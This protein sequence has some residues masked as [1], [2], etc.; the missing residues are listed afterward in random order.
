MQARNSM[1][2]LIGHVRRNINRFSRSIGLMTRLE[3]RMRSGLTILMYHRILPDEDCGTYPLSSLVMPVS[4]F[5][6]QMKWLAAHQEVR[7]VRDCVQQNSNVRRSER[8]LV[9]VTFDDGYSDNYE[10]AA[11]ILDKHGLKGTFFVTS[12]FVQ[13]G[14]P[15]WFDKA[16]HVWT[17]TPAEHRP[18]LLAELPSID[19]SLSGIRQWMESLKQAS[20][21][22]RHAVLE[23]TQT[24]LMDHL[25][26]DRFAPMTVEQLR[27]LNQRGHEVASHTVTHPILPQ[28]ADDDIAR[29]VN[30]AK[31]SIEGWLDDEVVGFCYPNGDSDERVERAL[32]SAGYAYACTTRP[33]L[34]V[35]AT[36][37]M[38]LQRVDITAQRVVQP[39]GSPDALGFRAEV[40]QWRQWCRSLRL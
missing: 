17:S 5:E 23:E 38:R 4:A 19:Q 27:D 9:A 8:A 18:S 1:S 11:P 20:P 6:A 29:E 37:P 40:C 13:T 36:D 16:A 14:G 33:G 7:T 28:L 30:D 35:Q 26:R 12:G 39:D 2:M 24:G 32:R 22:V 10:L 15:L 25:N 3:R 21:S 31:H 34:N